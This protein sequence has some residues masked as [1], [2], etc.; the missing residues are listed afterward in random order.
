MA[1]KK[2]CIVL[3]L[4]MEMYML[5]GHSIQDTAQAWQNKASTMLE[6]Q[7]KNACLHEEE[8]GVLTMLTSTRET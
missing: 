6:E 8:R 1:G 3:S 5:S 4:P 7:V 2:F